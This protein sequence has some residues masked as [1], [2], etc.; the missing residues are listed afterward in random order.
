MPTWSAPEEGVCA[1]RRQRGRLVRTSHATTSPLL[2][3]ERTQGWP[4]I[5][6][7]D[8]L[9]TSAPCPRS[10]SASGSAVNDSAAHHAFAAARCAEHVTRGLTP[11]NGMAEGVAGTSA[12]C[13]TTAAIFAIVLG[14]ILAIPMGGSDHTSLRG[15]ALVVLSSRAAISA[16]QIGR[17]HV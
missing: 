6:A 12:S 9:W 5:V 8:T 11:A 17:A 2:S 10:T 4:S 15:V 13:P 14:T 7:N 3:P 16:R 1:G